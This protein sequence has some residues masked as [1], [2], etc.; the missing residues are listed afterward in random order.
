MAGFDRSR[1]NL[2]RRTQ[3]Q[4]DT[5]DSS[6]GIG[7]QSFMDYSSTGLKFFKMGD[8]GTYHDINILPWRIT[9]K[10]HPEVVAGRAKVGDYD[11]VLDLMVHTRIGPNNGDYICPKKNFGKPCPICDYADELW[12]D[13][14]TKEEARK[15]FARRKCVYC[16]Q[17][18]KESDNGFTAKSETPEIFEVSHPVFSAELQSR[19]T[20]CLR[21]RG[22]VQFASPNDDGRVVSFNVIEG[23]MGNGKTFK[24]AGNFEFNERSEE[25]SDEVLEKCPSLDALMVLKTESQLKAALFGDPDDAESDFDNQQ[26]SHTDSS[27]TRFRDNAPARYDE[28]EREAPT[29]FRDDI[30]AHRSYA[31]QDAPVR[32]SEN[33]RPARQADE[34]A[35]MSARRESRRT[36][37]TESAPSAEESDGSDDTGAMPFTIDFNDRKSQP[38]TDTRPPVEE[39]PVAVEQS[40]TATR[41]DDVMTCKFGYTFGEDCETGPLC[42]RCPDAVYSKCQA[43]CQKI[44]NKA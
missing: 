7:R 18:M 13:P 44:R 40:G 24:K 2:G 38:T 20:A 26:E 11:Y 36:V 25:I 23:Q 17:E 33:L 41:G 16:V 8:V 31:E 39:Q 35:Y 4:T 43:A 42:G 37:P 5:R 29:R 1:I 15:L 12:K 19:A 10:N 28:S 22:V 30:P 3:Q 6:G 21:G 34:N 14:K 27:P 32:Q 9:T